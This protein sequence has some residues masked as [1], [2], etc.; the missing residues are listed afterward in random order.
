[1]LPIF[2]IM[3]SLFCWRTS[4]EYKESLHPIITLPLSFMVVC[5]FL[6]KT[7]QFFIFCHLLITLKIIMA[8]FKSRKWDKVG[9]NIHLLCGRMSCYLFMP[10]CITFLNV[11]QTKRQVSGFKIICYINLRNSGVV[12]AVWLYWCVLDSF[13]IDRSNVAILEAANISNMIQ[14][15]LL[16]S[17]FCS[18]NTTL[19]K[20][21]TLSL[22]I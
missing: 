9:K 7:R 2:F 20:T 6:K 4:C 19:Q 18:N 15:K 5:P 22:T 17:A 12:S 13:H 8:V 16:S 1:M 3:V 21:L 14:M 10:F 11:D